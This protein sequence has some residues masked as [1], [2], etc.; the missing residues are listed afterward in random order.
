M[1]HQ[2][3]TTLGQRL[4]QLRQARKWTQKELAAKLYMT[5]SHISKIERDRIRPRRSTLK[6]FADIFEVDLE[7]LE[8]L[9]EFTS[10]EEQLT[11]EDPDLVILLSK[12]NLLD[13]EQKKA[14][15]VIL[16][17]MIGLQQIRL[18]TGQEED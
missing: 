3:I 15:R 6:D 9:A 11:E 8:T 5:A 14:L 16:T 10:L 4:A 13:A 2:A 18:V 17:S 7:E 1:Y 12:I